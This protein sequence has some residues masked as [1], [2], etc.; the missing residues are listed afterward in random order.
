MKYADKVSQID[1]K[2]YA[3]N[4]VYERYRKNSAK[5]KCL[6]VTT[7]T[8]VIFDMN[9]VSTKNTTSALS[10]LTEDSITDNN[11]PILAH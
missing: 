2:I 3:N 7:P 5:L 10:T 4:I 9:S 1:K 11:P 6:T 8:L